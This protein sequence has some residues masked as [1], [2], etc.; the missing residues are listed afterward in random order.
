MSNPSV[1]RWIHELSQ[2]DDTAARRLWE[3]L[4]PRIVRI[5]EKNMKRN[6]AS[7]D[8]A[9]DVAQSCF[10]LLFQSIRNGNYTNIQDRDELWRLA[11]VVTL[12]RVRDRARRDNRERRGGG[13]DRI[14]LE[15]VM[16]SL[17]SEQLDPDLAA[18]TREECRRML[19]RLE[20]QD[21]QL[22][23]LLKVEGY[24]NEEIAD[25]LNCTR[26]TVQRR[27]NFIRDVWSEE[28]S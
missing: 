11:A 2:G 5:A 3:F 15:Q 10:H 7:T 19:D 12:N 6:S 17:S 22:V 1:T 20:R 13:R 26:R 23:A 9:E 25:Q 16:E 14:P 4:H 28:L 24:T 8:D 27:L 18:I 21:V